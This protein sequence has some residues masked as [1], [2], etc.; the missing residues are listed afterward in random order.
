MVRKLPTK[1]SW[2]QRYLKLNGCYLSV[3]KDE[4]LKQIH[5]RMHITD[6]VRIA[7]RSQTYFALYFP[8][9]TTLDCSVETVDE[10]VEWYNAFKTAS[11]DKY[12]MSL[13]SFDLV[14]QIGSGFQSTVYYA[15]MYDGEAVAVKVCNRESDAAKEFGI[16][17]KLEHPFIV[18]PKFNFVFN[19][20][21]YIGME[22][23]KLDLFA[24]MEHEVT[25]RDRIIYLAEIISAMAYVHSQ[26]VAVRDLKPENI[27]IDVDGHV[28]LAD[29]GLAGEL[30]AE[31]DKKFCGTLQYCAPEVVDGEGAVAASDVW[32]F[33]VTAFELL[34]GFTPFAH[35]HKSATVHSIV[36]DQIPF[37]EMATAEERELVSACLSK[38]AA[39]RPT[40]EKLKE[41]S[42]FAGVDWSAL[43]EKKYETDFVPC[44]SKATLDS[45]VEIDGYQ[46]E[47]QM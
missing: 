33:G 40:F 1:R 16:I 21:A 47:Q 39:Q 34:Y 13:D 23:E 6:A 25:A 18:R 8:D 35:S 10:V 15:T 32:C 41:A 14:R 9:G 27:L 46:I 11:D 44:D 37:P 26:N 43:D 12:E 7:I 3:C 17:Q 45:Q 2:Q 5:G 4:D 28:K 29:F 20:S 24:R 42:Y 31:G 22:L 19:G 36:N 38:D 30:K